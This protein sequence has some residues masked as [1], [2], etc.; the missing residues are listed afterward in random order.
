MVRPGLVILGLWIVWALSWMLAALWSSRVASRPDLG[1]QIRY[2]IPMVI[3]VVLLLI[4][5][6]RYEGPLRLWHVGWA[7]AWT[8]VG[9]EL[10]GI[11]FAW[12]A[13]I[14]L[15]ALWSGNV[16]RKANHRV[17]E[18]G[19]YG[20]VRH[21]IYT[22]LLLAL[23]ATATAKGTLP[24]LAGLASLLLGIWMKARLEERWLMQELGEADYVDYRARVPMLLPYGP[25]G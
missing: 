5:S 1:S 18:S 4:P 10:L 19:P 21:P 7:G 16:T 3:G 14:H 20:I 24:A 13:R 22:G 25:R 11:L 15:G 6:H 2:R 9:L 17:V 8:C 12:W 23:L